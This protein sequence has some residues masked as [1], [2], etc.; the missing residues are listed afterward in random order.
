LS[1][2]GYGCIDMPLRCEAFISEAT[3]SYRRNVSGDSVSVVTCGWN[4]TTCVDRS[5]ATASKLITDHDG[6]SA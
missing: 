5:C 2:T 1:N 6:C 3:C 4:G